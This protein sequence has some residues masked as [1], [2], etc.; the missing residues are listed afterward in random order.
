MPQLQDRV[1]IR[2]ISSKIKEIRTLKGITQEQFYNDT[3]IH[4]A[5]I[6]S[7]KA[8]ISVSTLNFICQY[9]NIKL[10]DFFKDF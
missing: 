8:N 7:G 6:E 10:E 4:I 2:R 1:L 5:R 9:F 3:G